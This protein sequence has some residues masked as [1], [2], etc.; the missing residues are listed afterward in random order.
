MQE[1]STSPHFNLLADR[2]KANVKEVGDTT[3]PP[4]LLQT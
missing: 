1:L 2:L 3:Q 4:P